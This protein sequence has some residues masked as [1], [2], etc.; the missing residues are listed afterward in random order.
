MISVKEINWR[1]VLVLTFIGA[2]LWPVAWSPAVLVQ[3]PALLK[4][5]PTDPIDDEIYQAGSVAFEVGQFGTAVG[6]WEQFLAENPGSYSVLLRIADAHEALDD[7]GAM[8]AALE[9]FL[10]SDPQNEQVILRL[11]GAHVVAGQMGKAAALIDRVLA[12]DPGNALRYYDVGELYVRG[13]ALDEAIEAYRGALAAEPGLAV[14]QKQIGLVLVRRRD[15]SGAA[16]AFEVFL[17]ME[18]AN[19]TD[20]EIVRQLLEVIEAQLAAQR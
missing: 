3:D 12:K 11:A 7:F 8:Q 20:A 5:V 15:L 19:S 13:G 1:R 2:L 10:R 6:K 17:E 9:R 18:S 14:A 16:E 4:G